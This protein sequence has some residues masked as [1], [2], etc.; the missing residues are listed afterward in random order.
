MRLP[1]A[2]LAAAAHALGRSTAGSLT[3]GF[4]ACAAG[5][6]AARM[7][8]RGGARGCGDGEAKGC[9]EDDCNQCTHIGILLM[10]VK[11]TCSL[12]AKARVQR[13]YHSRDGREALM[14]RKK[15]VSDIRRH[16]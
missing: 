8:G 16:V 2:A 13:M 7:G 6:G 3:S 4:R 5:L 11:D 15:Q 14:P 12:A 10:K 9:G 1:G